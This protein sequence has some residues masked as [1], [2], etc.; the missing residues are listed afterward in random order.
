[1]AKTDRT[2]SA[3]PKPATILV[4]DDDPGISRLI[5]QE[6]RR[7]GHQVASVKSGEEAIGWIKE[8]EAD[9]VLL[10]L[11]LPGLGGDEL[12]DRLDGLHDH[13]PFI[14]ITGQGDERVAVE[15]MKRGA[16]DYLVKDVNFI[17]LVPTVVQRALARLEEQAQLSAAE[18]ALRQS[19]EQYHS[20]FSTLIEG[21]CIIEVIFDAEEHP[22]DYRFLEV[23]P[24]FEAQTGLRDAQGKRMRELA[25]EHEE[26]WFEIYGHIA[27]TGEPR[28]FVSEAKALQRW[29][30]V[31]A[32][33]FGEAGSRKVAILFNDIS[34]A[35]RAE[36]AMR[37][38]ERRE[39]ERAEELAALLDA[40]PTPIFIADDQDCLHIQGNRAADELL[41]IPREGEA[42]LSAP[43]ARRPQH[44][45]TIKDG[46]E[47]APEELP[48]QRA[49]KG[50]PVHG[51]E[52]DLLFDD[53]TRRDVLAFAI[54]LRNEAGEPRGSITVLMD[55]TERK[56]AEQALARS[57]AELERRVTERTAELTQANQSLRESRMAAL[58]LMEDAI[59]AREKTEAAQVALRESEARFRGFFE[60]V[61]V[62][63]VE[64]GVDGRFTRVNDRFCAITG[65]SREELTGGMSPVILAHPEDAAISQE[66]VQKILQGT[67][68]SYETERRCVRKDGT[69]IWINGTATT[70]HNE[71]GSVRSIVGIAED[72]TERKEIEQ[73]LTASEERLRLFIK[74]T[75]A[76][77]VMFDREMR[78]LVV[79]DRW[80]KDFR[81][82]TN[83]L[84][85]RSHY[86]V[87]PDLPEHW[88]QIHQRCLAGATES[89]ERD[90][91]PRA[92]GSLD[93]LKWECRPWNDDEGNIGGIVLFAEII[94]DRVRA[95]DEIL[96]ARRFAESTLEAI[97]ASLAVLDS[98]GKI[99]STNEAWTAFAEANGGTVN[100]GGVGTNYLAVCDA[101]AGDGDEEA[102]RFATG[103]RE[104]MGGEVTRFSMEYAC[105]SP[106]QQRWFVGYVTPFMGNG[107]HSVVIAHVDVSER[108]RAEQVIRRLNEELEKRVD[109]R[110]AE[111]KH[112]NA[113]LKEQMAARKQLEEEILHISEHEKQRIGQDLHDDLGQQLAGI[114]LLSDLL[115]AS[116]VEKKAPEAEDAE[117][118]ATLLK[119]ALGLT[120]SLARGLHPVAV[121]AGGL[122]AALDELA[123]RTSTMFR[124]Q[125]RC[126]CPPAL[127]MDNT[128]ATHL[129]RIAQEAV[130]NAVKHGQ[131]KE[132]DIELSTNAH[133]TVLSVK[134]Q[135]KGE[136]QG[137][138]QSRRGGGVGA[139]LDPK[140]RGM[141]LRIMSYRADM[142]GGTLDIRRSQSGSGMTVVCTIPTPPST[143]TTHT[144]P[145]HG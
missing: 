110:T 47:L 14:I 35:K 69:V 28:R 91:F 21:F 113:R 131:A 54:P 86:E 100:T 76:P 3:P 50:V 145:A 140:H 39:R 48:A 112:T 18:N 143:T 96:Q 62:G 137:A 63:T 49:A 36:E 134:D 42:S 55:I 61:G 121:Q 37:A 81:L 5:S 25:P 78:Y 127:G 94:N 130:T 102:A 128:T 16:L 99:L 83:E 33:R 30:D 70:I 133:H 56:L 57:H 45:K 58:N 141:G 74:H 101:A 6:L 90:Q 7:E 126:K 87:F 115:K 119:D 77:V 65:Y 60:N 17:A 120:R 111:L 23:N 24:A 117:K 73:A 53:G 144:E 138:G 68:S 32:F 142:I 46:R 116:L 109:E 1:M 79:S 118:I 8:N 31:S 2:M 15:M 82:N 124:I 135:G 13:L 139:G 75:P 12:I 26:K 104:V 22:V 105:H 95:E 52:F 132:I 107:P 9:L 122:I 66:R 89:S 19:Q 11:K 136:G 97:P 38:S 40:V 4:V 85:G 125:C 93:W 103:I 84:A 129:Y 108:K 59:A 10:D 106:S 114:W 20:L 51:F 64:L 41:R 72:I 88:R 80:A 67:L 29:F 92:D 98:E 34:E 43:G 27:L 44:F 71:D 123:G